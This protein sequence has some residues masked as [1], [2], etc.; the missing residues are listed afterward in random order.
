MELYHMVTKPASQ[1]CLPKD[2]PCPLALSNEHAHPRVSSP[3]RIAWEVHAKQFDEPIKEALARAANH[4]AISE[5]RKLQARLDHTGPLKVSSDNSD[6]NLAMTLRDCTCFVQIGD[7][8]STTN[9]YPDLKVRLSDFDWKDPGVKA[10]R[11][12]RAE[13]ELIKGG[14]YTAEW[15]LCGGQLYHPP[16]LCLLEWKQRRRVDEME[17]ICLQ[18]EGSTICLEAIHMEGAG[19]LPPNTKIYHHSTDLK[20]LHKKLRA[21]KKEPSGAPL[22][23][24][25]NPYRTD[26]FRMV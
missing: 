14:Y 3:L 22:D 18:D 20:I 23:S 7:G 12:R 10:D 11:W 13:E 17:V 15:I 4:T 26:P 5:L 8:Q 21:Y 24:L 1:K 9:P 6:F 25:I 2:K 19:Q 16:T